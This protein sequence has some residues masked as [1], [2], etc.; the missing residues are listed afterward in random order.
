[1]CPVRRIALAPLLLSLL[2]IGCGGADIPNLGSRGHTIVCLGDSITSGTG[3]EPGPA[4][5][6]LLQSRLGTDVINQGVPGDTAE[7]GLARVDEVLAAD[8]WLVVVELGGNDILNRIPPERT[9]AAL[10]QIVQRLLAAKVAVLLVELD[11]PF[12]GRYAEIYERLGDDFDVPVL[13]D[14]LGDILTDVRLKADPI[15][16]NAQG[17]EVLAAALAKE[18][19]PMIQA[20]RKLGR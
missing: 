6:A 3:A 14:T 16:P 7:E 12:A 13:D 10:R 2:L 1:M 17:H 9:E 11:V 15:H 4:F 20:R 5:P 18:I 8:P 19:E